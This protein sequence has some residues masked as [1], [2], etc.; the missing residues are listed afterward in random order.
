LARNWS[1]KPTWTMTTKMGPGTKY[2]SRKDVEDA[3]MPMLMMPY[4]ME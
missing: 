3:D 1:R 4:A 2:S